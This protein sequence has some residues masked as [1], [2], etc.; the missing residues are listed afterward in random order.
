M[1]PFPEDFER[2]INRD[3][4]DSDPDHDNKKSKVTCP[5]CHGRGTQHSIKSGMREIC[6]ACDAKGW[7]QNPNEQL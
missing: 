5:C 6:P 1:I 2:D 3:F 4:P 7:I